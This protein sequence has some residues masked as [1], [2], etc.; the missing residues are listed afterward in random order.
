VD[1]VAR[2]EE[3]APVDIEVKCLAGRTV[4]LHDDAGE[5]VGPAEIAL[6]L[7]AAADPR[8]GFWEAFALDS[9]TA[10]VQRV[11]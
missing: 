5:W 7:L 9:T 1:A 8:V 2:L 11:H 4:W 3:T 6:A 10:Q